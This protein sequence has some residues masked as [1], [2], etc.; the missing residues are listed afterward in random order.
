MHNPILK[1]ESIS[2]SGDGIAYLDN[3]KV[4]I[5]DVLI[6]EEVEVRLTEVKDSYAQAEVIKYLKR[7]LYRTPSIC[8]NNCGAC[9]YLCCSYDY[10]IK[11]KQQEVF[12]CF[13]KDL[14]FVA[15]YQNSSNLPFERMDNPYNYRNKAVYAIS[16]IGNQ[17]MVGLYETRSHSI[18]EIKNCCLEA[19]WINACRDSIK[20]FLLS[21]KEYLQKF[22]SS[23]KYLFFR[24]T[25]DSEKIVVFVV[26]NEDSVKELQKFDLLTNLQ[27]LLQ[28]S[29]QKIFSLDEFKYKAMINIVININTSEGNRILG[30]KN[31]TLSGN[32]FINIKLLDNLF[33]I[34][35]HAFL[36]INLEQTK[37][38]YQYAINELNVCKDDNV[39][40]L[41]CGAGTIS[42]Y[43]ARFV[44]NVI[45]IECVPSAIDNAKLN[46]KNNS[47]YN[48]TFYCGNVEDVLP[49]INLKEEIIS[50]AILDPARKGCEQQV[51]DTL[52][53]NNINKIVYISCNYKT[54]YRDIQYAKNLGY[55]VKS[56]KVFDLFPH[57][58]HVET[59]VL[60][61]R[62]EVSERIRFDVNVEDLQG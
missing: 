39:L 38:L 18:V 4:F 20:E 10:E 46:A 52:A 27:E 53:S 44:K 8:A 40:D 32:E 36:Q 1:I 54:Q 47:V 51:F 37:K 56:F 14:D 24:G 57:T 19:M 22:L 34:N 33:E 16:Y 5:K 2:S 45:G 17:L 28:V 3:K 25:D 48:A 35:T 49:S 11:L 59:V 50:A 29:I 6:G 12:E 13:N 60:L 43:L 55:Q 61:S 15:L 42:L 9:H 30:D 31:I 41:Y 7:S 21:N 62:K 26:N 58:K 23:L